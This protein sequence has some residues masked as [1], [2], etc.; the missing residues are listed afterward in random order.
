M[1]HEEER[2]AVIDAARCIDWHGLDGAIGVLECRAA[3]TSPG[4]YPELEDFAARI[5][6]L[7][8]ACL[9]LKAAEVR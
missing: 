8:N 1:S 2:Q 4:V 5:A 7:K 9:L 3:Q 6:A